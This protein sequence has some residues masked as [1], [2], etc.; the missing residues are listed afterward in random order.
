MNN[1]I[2]IFFFS[3]LIVYFLI[4]N[5]SPALKSDSKS[6]IEH[7][8]SPSINISVNS[9]INL[10]KI[11][12]DY[13]DSNVN[14]LFDHS[15]INLNEGNEI[16]LDLFVNALDNI[17]SN[18]TQ[19]APT[20][21]DLSLNLN[22]A[23]FVSKKVI[24]N[25]DIINPRKFQYSSGDDY[26][27]TGRVSKPLVIVP[28]VEK[29]PLA[30]NLKISEKKLE[31]KIDSQK[32]NPKKEKVIVKKK[33]VTKEIV[34]KEIVTEE[35]VTEEVVSEE[36]VTQ[37]VVTQE[38]VTQEVVSEEVV[39]E[40]VVTHINEL[41]NIIFNYTKNSGKIPVFKKDSKQLL[42]KV[43]KKGI[44]NKVDIVTIFNENF[45]SKITRKA[46][47][48]YIEINITKKDPNFKRV[49]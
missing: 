21:S 34:A 43:L 8:I 36:V 44:L 30:E 35:V 20:D 48:K 40:E 25:P 10:F 5:N 46:I 18:N 45:G 16:G 12:S 42:F 15:S 26:T 22:V 24:K 4:S 49:I 1:K 28:E 38:V 23:D 47:N 9:D 32:K 17:S 37:E 29:T 19:I 2:I 13:L 3:I 7:V 27:E 11:H 39:S 6:L 31:V 14:K 33:V 41:N